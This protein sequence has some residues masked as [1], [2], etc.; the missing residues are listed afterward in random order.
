M[1]LKWHPQI[2]LNW[3]RRVNYFPA[4]PRSL[5][6][7]KTL[8]IGTKNRTLGDALL[9]TSLPEKLKAAYPHLRIYTY[10]RGLNPLVFRGNPSVEGIQ[11]APRALYGDDCMA[12]SGHH[13]QLKESF[14]GLPLSQPPRPRI[15]L[16][17]S[18]RERARALVGSGKP[19]C[20]IHPWGHTW[21][22]AASRNF[23]EP[24][25]FWEP[26]IQ[27]WRHRVRFWQLGL[28]GHEKIPGC[29]RVCFSGRHPSAVRELFALISCADA[30]IGVDSGP[31]H[32]ARAFD[33]PS[34]VLTHHGAVGELFEN[35]RRYPYFLKQNFRYAF[36]YEENSHLEADRVPTESLVLRAGEFLERVSSA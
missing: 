17:A 18:E 2:E 31:M 12:G 5:A 16:S 28:E 20:V 11:R 4:A 34:A 1:F 23:W 6:E 14:F 24:L 21:N 7:I 36:L 25:K 32:I 26:L 29:E 27:E 33:V 22:A 8:C 13:I 10:P 3:L 35:R 30:F 15:Y 19:L 9:L